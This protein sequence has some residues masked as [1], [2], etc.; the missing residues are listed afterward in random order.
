PKTVEAFKDEG[1]V[2]LGDLVDLINR[3]GASWWRSVPRIGAGRAGSIMRF[4]QEWPDELGEVAV[5]RRHLVP[6][7]TFDLLP[8]LDPIK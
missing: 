4:L 3:R 8:V 7:D 1:I 5:E 2:T 6:A